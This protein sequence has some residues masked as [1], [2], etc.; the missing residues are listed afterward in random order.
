MSETTD[1]AFEYAQRLY[2]NHLE[3]YR[4]AEHKAELVL[5]VDGIFLSL[6]SA[7]LTLEAGKLRAVVREFGTETWVALGLMG[8]ALLGS[9]ASAVICLLSR[10]STGVRVGG[11]S[12][13]STRGRL[14]NVRRAL[15]GISMSHPIGARLGPANIWFFEH[16]AAHAAEDPDGFLDHA[17]RVSRRVELEAMLHQVLVLS[18]NVKAKHVWANRAFVLTAITLASFAGAIATYFEQL[19]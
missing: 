13:E 7:S 6:L 19:A 2:A 16:I 11:A 10:H 1:A 17:K 8:I 9:L 12:Q 18:G 14:A 3:W 4:V 15:G 5:T